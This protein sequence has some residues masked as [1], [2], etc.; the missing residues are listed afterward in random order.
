MIK[1]EM[2]KAVGTSLLIITFSSFFGFM[3]DIGN[4]TIDW[5]FLLPFSGI[6]LMGILIGSKLSNFIP[7]VVL[8]KYFAYFTLIMGITTITL[9]VFR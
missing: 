1:M 2:K 4:Q 3:G 8:K 5:N 9:E 7:T 6:A